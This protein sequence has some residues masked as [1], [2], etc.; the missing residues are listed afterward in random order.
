MSASQVD[1]ELDAVGGAITAVCTA[2][3]DGKTS[4]I[5]G[6][7]NTYTIVVSNSG[8]SNVTGALINDP[9]PAIFTNATWTA[10]YSSGSSGAASGSGSI[11]G[12]AVN[13]L[14]G[15]ERGRL[16]LACLE[17]VGTRLNSSS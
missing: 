1:F 3:T 6:Q 8:P 13:L 14:S 4:V 17:K 7:S 12:L 16:A 9:F 11:S 10:S 5:P 2:K 15:G